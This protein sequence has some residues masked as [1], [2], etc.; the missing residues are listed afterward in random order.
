MFLLVL[1]QKRSEELAR[2]SA[3]QAESVSNNGDKSSSGFKGSSTTAHPLSAVYMDEFDT[4]VATLNIVCYATYVYCFI[5]A[6]IKEKGS[7]F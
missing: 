4:Y 1:V 2:A 7:S 3:E 5:F 6:I